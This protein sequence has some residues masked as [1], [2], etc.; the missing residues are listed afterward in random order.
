MLSLQ[1][2]ARRMTLKKLN[3]FLF[4]FLLSCTQCWAEKIYCKDGDTV[5]AEIISRNKDTLWVKHSPGSVG[6]DVKNIIKI[7]NDNGLLSKY[8]VA[9]LRGQIQG[10][11]KEKKYSEAAQVCGVLLGSSPDNV[12]LRYLRAMLNQKIGDTGKAAEDY[13]F[14][15]NH[16]AADGEIFNNLGAVY[17]KQKKYAQAQAMFSEAVKEA[18]ARPE[19]HN[20][21]AELFMELK[22]FERAI[23]EYKLVTESEP[24]NTLALYNLGVA[25][26]SNGGYALA[27]EQWE[28]ILKLQ[29]EDADAKKALEYLKK[30]GR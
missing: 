4:I 26:K 19:F 3:L 1:N 7:E 20:N 17:A 21:S 11:I 28:K 24:D 29:P 2:L 13:E 25:Y 6:M 10:L 14:L 22:D 16:N 5:N 27:R 12:E 15:V 18:P 30:E 23:G 9:N 8:D